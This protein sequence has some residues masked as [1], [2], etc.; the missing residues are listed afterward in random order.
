MASAT[1]ASRNQ[2]ASRRSFPRARIHSASSWRVAWVLDDDGLHEGVLAG[3]EQLTAGLGG[4]DG[5]GGHELGDLADGVDPDVLVAEVLGH[6]APASTCWA[7]Q[8]YRASYTND[9]ALEQ[10]VV[11]GLDVEPTARQRQQGRG[12]G[13]GVD[14]GRMSAACTIRARRTSAGSSPRSN[15]SIRTSKVHLSPRWS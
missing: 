5:G 13:I 4:G 2:I 12:E 14:L 15:S 8:A 7:H 6:A 11:V 9:G 1:S 3:E 10:P